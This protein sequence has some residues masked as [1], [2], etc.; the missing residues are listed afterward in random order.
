MASLDLVCRN[1]HRFASYPHWWV[2]L[3]LKLGPELPVG[4][5]PSHW[6]SRL[7]SR[8]LMLERQPTIT[9]LLTTDNELCFDP[10]NAVVSP[11]FTTQRVRIRQDALLETMT[12]PFVASLG[13]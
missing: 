11:E 12:G 7:G 8:L 13:P 2:A 3:V 1:L 6:I 5:P 4:N 9:L 10:L